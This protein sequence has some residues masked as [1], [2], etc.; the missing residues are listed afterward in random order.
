MQFHT[1]F[2]FTQERRLYYEQLV[3][4]NGDFN[5][6]GKKDLLV[7]NEK[8]A[9]SVHFFLSREKG[10]NSE[11]DLKFNCPEPIDSWEVMDL[12]GDGV[13]DL[14][15]KVRERDAYRIFISERQKKKAENGR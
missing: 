14:I 2:F 6:D 15:V 3:S 7:R 4:L 8:K 9:I 1:E 5:G 10:F 11:V 13:S 12:N